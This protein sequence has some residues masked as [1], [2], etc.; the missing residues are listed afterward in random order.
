[1]NINQSIT[2]QEFA[3]HFLQV[4]KS[5]VDDPQWLFSN[6]LIATYNLCLGKT[7]AADAWKDINQGCY[8]IKRAMGVS[9]REEFDK[10]YH[11]N[12]KIVVQTVFDKLG[13]V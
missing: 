11:G 7:K 10:F 12:F 2:P 6:V 4:V 8:A 3:D 9:S 5:D 1:M 13:I